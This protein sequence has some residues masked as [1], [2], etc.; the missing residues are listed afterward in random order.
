VSPV[1]DRGDVPAHLVYSGSIELIDAAPTVVVLKAV[2]RNDGSSTCT[3]H[4]G[5]AP[6]GF[7]IYSSAAHTARRLVYEFDARTKPSLA[8]GFAVPLAPR[9][10]YVMTSEPYMLSGRVAAGRYDVHVTVHHDGVVGEAA[11]GELEIS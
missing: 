6:L 4:A 3:I 1:S 7:R 9:E 8:I 10:E 11:A 5:A 2:I